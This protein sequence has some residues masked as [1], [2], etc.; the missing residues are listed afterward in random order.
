M[1]LS[2]GVKV[3]IEAKPKTKSSL[4]TQSNSGLIKVAHGDALAVA[5]SGLKPGSEVAVW[6]FSTPRLLGTVVVDK[7]GKVNG[8]FDIG[9]NV[10]A[11]LHTAQVSGLDVKGESVAFNVGVELISES[12]SSAKQSIIKPYYILLSVA[13][14]ILGF[15]LLV[16][17]LR[18]RRQV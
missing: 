10:P 7:N 8:V 15:I 5:G 1:E 12:G 13:I 3:T 18:R 4:L 9:P 11:G 14:G 2:V 17:I 6:L 16:V